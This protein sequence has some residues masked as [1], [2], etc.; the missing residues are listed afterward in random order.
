MG[1]FE[2]GVS[3]LA[4]SALTKDYPAY[5]QFYVTARCNLTCEQCNVIY[6]NADQQECTTEQAMQIAEN[7]A[8]IGTS[9]VLLTGGE[10]FVRRDIVTIAKA[11]MDNGI[12]PRLQTNGLASR[13]QLEEMVKIGSH[14]I[15]ISLD[16]IVPDLQ[17]EINGGF[18][19]SWER[20][21]N[22]ISLVNNIFPIN[23]FCVF[24]TVL[25]PK[26][27]DQITGVIKF[28]TAIGWWVSLV[29]A[30]Q[31][32]TSEPRSFSTFD[33]E[34][35][36]TPDQYARVAEVLEEVKHLRNSGYNVYD[37]DEYLDDIYRFITR[38]PIGWRRRNGGVCDSPNLYFAIQ[39]NGDMA[40]CCD[41]RLP[42]SVPVYDSEF[43]A[44]YR[45]EQIREQVF[46]VTSGCSGCMYGS[47]PEIS[48]STRFFVPM[49]RRARLFLFDGVDRQLKRLSKE[50]I[51]AVAN[52]VAHE[53]GLI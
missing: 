14:D 11:M 43:P 13:K 4:L 5:V 49:F 1:F 6:A 26:N 31:T 25:A 32:P 33:I 20:A 53:S 47:F 36:F 52:Q 12:H 42:Q 39:P 50:E 22:T 23:S 38:Q 18:N 27:I 16:S 29:P 46:N 37:S 44:L 51:M 2:G 19:K 30:H 45:S 28:A 48:I 34:L 10:P 15:S 9:V 3:K 40:V 7:L 35:C 8:A 21:I 24:G 41:Y 17:D